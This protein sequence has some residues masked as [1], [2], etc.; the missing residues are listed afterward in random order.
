MEVVSR[1]YNKRFVFSVEADC[2]LSA[3]GAEFSYIIVI[4]VLP[5][6]LNTVREYV[7]HTA[8]QIIAKRTLRN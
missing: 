3:V 6:R 1:I 2:V 8:P 4:T 5:P 7:L